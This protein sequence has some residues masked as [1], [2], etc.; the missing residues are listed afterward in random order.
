[1]ISI[2]PDPI[3]ELPH[4]CIPLEGVTAHLL[5]AENHQIIFMHFSED[6]ELPEHRHEAQWGIVLEGRIDLIIGDKQETYTKGQRYYIPGG[7]PHSG[8]IHKGYADIT[9]FNEPHR[10]RC[11]KEI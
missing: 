8:R 9:F 6:I 7:V 1:M 2:F 10:Y 3:R 11:A 4:A 5:Q